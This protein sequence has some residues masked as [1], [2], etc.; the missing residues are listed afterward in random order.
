MAWLLLTH[1]LQAS[2]LEGGFTSRSRLARDDTSTGGNDGNDHTQSS[3]ISSV[4][5]HHARLAWRQPSERAD[6]KTQ[7]LVPGGLRVM[8]EPASAPAT[9]STGKTSN[10]LAELRGERIGLGRRCFSSLPRNRRTLASAA[11]L[12]AKPC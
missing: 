1:C 11:G 5:A 3:G 10:L 8:E 6:R 2:D 12:E 9:I 7:A 4:S